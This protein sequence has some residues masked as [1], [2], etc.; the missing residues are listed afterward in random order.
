MSIERSL[1]VFVRTDLPARLWSRLLR[2]HAPGS[3][4]AP[5]RAWML[6]APSS[7]YMPNV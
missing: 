6:T 7:S 5:E 2:R 4:M 1:G 3:S